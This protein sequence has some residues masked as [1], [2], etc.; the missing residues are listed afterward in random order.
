M[1][2][3]AYNNAKNASTG[4]MLF[5]L[6]C[7]YHFQTF[8]GKIINLCSQSK[9][10][11]ELANELKELMAI[12]RENFQYAQKLQKQYHYKHAK[13]K[14]YAPGKKFWLN[15]KYIK[16]KQNHKLEAKFFKPFRVLHLTGKTS[17]QISTIKEMEN[18][19]YFLYVIAGTRYHKEGASK[20]SH[21]VKQE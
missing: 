4:H 21:R 2:E 17:L 18:L 9:S 16:T 8:Y 5:V 12:C 13:P 19:Q 7:G 3:F 11:D 1:A 10:V 20:N 14:S 15:S 6:N